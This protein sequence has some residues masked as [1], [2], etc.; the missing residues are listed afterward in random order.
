MTSEK[1]MDILSDMLTS[2]VELLVEKGVITQEEY[3][4][5]VK[6]RLMKSAALT[7][8]DDLED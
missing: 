4:N 1:D 8:F 6:E 2:V 5:K 3:E 7:K